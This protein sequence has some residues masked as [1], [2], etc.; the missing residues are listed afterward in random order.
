[1]LATFQTEAG[2]ICYQMAG[3]IVGLLNRTMLINGFRYS[4]DN[5]AVHDVMFN[6]NVIL[7]KLASIV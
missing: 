6:L 7:I 1:M 4:N 2:L 5:Q 3:N